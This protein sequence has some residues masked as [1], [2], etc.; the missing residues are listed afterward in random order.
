MSRTVLE[1][2]A[3]SR[4]ERTR[5]HVFGM[6][7][8]VLAEKPS[9]ARDI[10]RVLGAKQRRDG[11]LEGNGYA[12]TWALG[13]LVA[14]AEPHQIRPQ[15]KRW[16]A[17][18]LPMIPA[19]WPLE[20]VSSTRDRFEVVSRL[21]RDPEVEEI[22]CATDA[23]REGELIFRYIYEAA[24]VDK[25]VKRLWISSLTEEAIRRGFSSLRD[26]SDYDALADA[27]RGRSRAD[28]LVGMNLSRAYTLRGGETVSVGRV[29]TPTLAMLVEREL[30]IRDFV[31][32]DYKEVVAE[33]RLQDARNYEGVWFRKLDRS[34]DK[35]SV[36]ASEALARRLPADGEEAERI[37]ARA[38]SGRCEIESVEARQRKLPPPPLY[39]LTELQRHANRLFGYSA[40]KTLDIAQSL[41]ETKKLLSYPRTDSRH[42]SS[43][44][45]A[46]LGAI[47]RA[48]QEPYREQL[49][50]GTGTRPLGSR[51]VDDARVSDHHAIV[52][53]PKSPVSVSLTRDETNL[54]D[55]VCRRLLSAWHPDH[56]YS[57]T[58]VITAIHNDAIVD[59]YRS[60]GTSVDQQGWK[61]LDLKRK[62][63][64][65]AQNDSNDRQIPPGLVA[66]LSVEVSEAR[67]IAR[68]TRPPRHFTDSSLLT[69]METAGRS[70]DD[71][72][73]S[74]AMRTTGLGTPATRASIIETLIARGYATR[75]KKALTATEKGITLISVVHPEVRSPRMTGEWEARLQAIQAGKGQ[76]TEFMQGIE[77]YVRDVV[78]RVV[79]QGEVAPP[80]EPPGAPAEEPGWVRMEVPSDAG[81]PQQLNFAVAPEPTDEPRLPTPRVRPEPTPVGELGTLLH[82]RFGFETFRA[83]QQ[84]VCEAL[85]QGRDALLVMPTG[86]GKS[87]CYQLPGIARAGTTVVVSPLI[88]LM[89]DQVVKL[90]EQGF[91]AERIHSGRQRA[92][93]R[94]VCSDY[95]AGQLDFLF[96]AP[97]RLGVPGFPEMLARRKPAL[98]AVDEAHCIS[99]WGHDFRPD[100]RML[101]DRLPALRP[102]PIIALTATATPLVQ[103]DIVKQLGISQGELHIHGFRRDNIFI[104]LVEMRPGARNGAAVELLSKP[105]HRPAIVYSPTRK[106][107]E[108]LARHLEAHVPSAVY[109]A[110]IAAAKRDRVQAGFLAGEV[111]VI[112]ATIA[113]GMG[114]DKPD[115]RTVV[116]TAL[117]ASIEG[118]YQEI[119]RAGRDGLPSRA[120]LYHSYADRRTHEWFLDRD[121]PDESLLLEVQRALRPEPIPRSELEGQ[122]RMAP[123]TLEKALEKL[124]I[125]GGALIDPEDRVTRGHDAWQAAYRLQREHKQAQLD[126]VSRFSED[127]S[128]HMLQLVKHFGDQ[129]D[130]GRRC[131]HC[132]SC[133]PDEAVALDECPA[134]EREQKAMCEILDAL[135]ERDG[136][137][138]GRLH[139][140]LFGKALER[141]EFEVL[142]GG[143]VRAR[144]VHEQADSF[145]S[146]G[147]TIHFRR[148]HL[149]ED[150]RRTRAADVASVK[151]PKQ[152]AQ[153][154]PARSRRRKRQPA[155]SKLT[156]AAESAASPPAAL[157]EALKRWRSQEAKRRRCP[158]FRI[159]TDRALFGIASEI[160]RDEESLLGIK[161]MGPTLVKKYGA[162]ILAITNET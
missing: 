112:V 63:P 15:W 82:E 113:F 97:E 102:A 4:I 87:L 77:G 12:V 73:L 100:Y 114:I 160:P 86:A 68:R 37:V 65:G 45:A 136:Q 8:A 137:S 74:D 106:K 139:K 132:A 120:V 38:R 101:G 145:E 157:V 161:G 138:K 43:D 13:H 98:V 155:S 104:E 26:A 152:T 121:Y 10:A 90:Q 119:G 122:L 115:V 111:E 79:K 99:Q 84:A 5:D 36:D 162:D 125:H 76:L 2:R 142:L 146:E 32:E 117:P 61:I 40:K 148:L 123:E 48:I 62:A 72:Q 42:L 116:H 34:D 128:C 11:V 109:H 127:R 71:K 66:G 126:D 110:G 154:T 25:P 118:Y 83:H 35:K 23:G 103:R 14:V 17:S 143:L 41:Y 78:Q 124:W 141:K 156:A 52:P 96:I 129:E 93:S 88:A 46:D 144:F 105:E 140:V 6:T 81:P 28:W 9:V 80:P 91:A 108:E 58:T 49:A 24:G 147:R 22:V 67:A 70:L 85:T 1:R 149:S 47:V 55:L 18:E 30:A 159:L 16:S 27:A 92:E 3:L 135:R 64:A 56:L 153:P 33:F 50:P 59:R 95:L 151:L 131:G 158:A 44:V 130:S 69:G 57:T 133:L 134:N 20:I 107:A 60:T 39:D 21:L 31:P 51:Y 89:E 53:T 54:Y 94:R 19:K 7:I 150:G 75:D 29:Q